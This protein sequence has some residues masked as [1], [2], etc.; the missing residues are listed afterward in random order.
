MNDFFMRL[1]NLQTRAVS[2]TSFYTRATVLVFVKVW[3]FLKSKFFKS[4]QGAYKT[5]REA[6][7][8]S[9]NHMWCVLSLGLS[10]ANVEIASKQIT[11]CF[12]KLQFPQ[13]WMHKYLNTY[14]L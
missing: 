10:V 2:D 7:M 5:E 4:K 12:N 11:K 3:R 6:A 13:L 14:L 9:L 8:I 1:K